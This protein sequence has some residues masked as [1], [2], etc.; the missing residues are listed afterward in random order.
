VALY[1]LKFKPRI[2]P[3]MWGGRKLQSL[4]NKPLPPDQP[5]GECWEIFDFPPGIVDKSV[6]W[7]SSIVANG[8]L[9]GVSLHELVLQ[10]Y[11]DLLGDVPLAQPGGQF[12]I[13]IKFLDARE[14][15]SIQVHPDQKYADA[16]PGAYLK[17]EAWV[18][19]QSEPGA[20][21]FKGLVPGTSPDYFKAAIA[22]GHCERLLNSLPVK[23]GDVF[24]LPSGTVH[25]IGGGILAAEVQTPSDTTFRVYDFN[26]VDPSTG[27]TRQLHIEQALE[28]IHFQEQAPT[29]K[30]LDHASALHVMEKRLVHCEYFDLEEI[31]LPAGATEPLSSG[32][33]VVWIMI[34]GNAGVSVDE[35]PQPVTFTRG[36]TL[37]L[38]AVMKNARLHTASDCHWLEVT[39]P[40]GA[41]QK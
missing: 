9:T 27:K 18:I 17:S 26:R 38:P 8:P 5:I 16:H 33:P 20:R 1:P 14:D 13:L 36:D 4:L 19:V 6:G 40:V 41:S 34:E 24:Y 10:R 22:Q 30:S 29:P 3:K 25:A 15:L 37:L 39:F 23:P 32:K 31:R 11:P 21:L 2:L 7:V 12:P 35:L 28:C